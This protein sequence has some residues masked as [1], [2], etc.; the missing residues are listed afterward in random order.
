MSEPKGLTS[1]WIG[2]IGARGAELTYSGYDR[3]QLR[4]DQWRIEFEPLEAGGAVIHFRTVS[5]PLDFPES[6]S[7]APMRA[8]GFAVFASRIARDPIFLGKLTPA[9]ELGRCGPGGEW[10]VTPRVPRIEIATTIDRD[11]GC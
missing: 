9:I 7:F 6:E 1:V 2:L 3:V 10:R 11:P 5:P 8:T 4:N